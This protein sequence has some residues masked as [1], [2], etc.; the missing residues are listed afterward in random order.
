MVQDADFPLQEAV[1]RA[2][3]LPTA[4]TFPL[5]STVAMEELEELQDTF[6][7]AALEGE[8]LAL[9]RVEPPTS[10][11]VL[12]GDTDTEV[13]AVGSGSMVLGLLFGLVVAGLL[14]GLV[15]AGFWVASAGLD[16]SGFGSGSSTTSGRPST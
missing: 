9:S 14:F 8:T 10:S 2:V 11:T 16:G 5:P 3:P 12:E 7:L 1:I 6:W 15:A 13:T 4:L